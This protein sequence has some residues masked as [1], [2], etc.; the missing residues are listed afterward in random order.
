MSVLQVVIHNST[1]LLEI[2]STESVKVFGFFWTRYVM[3]WT[4]NDCITNYLALPAVICR[5]GKS[6]RMRN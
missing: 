1:Y 2:F 6:V 4:L 3:I 5:C